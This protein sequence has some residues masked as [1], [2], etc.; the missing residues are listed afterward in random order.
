MN[1]KDMPNSEAW[2]E[3]QQ[4][5][6]LNN[7]PF[8]N[9]TSR[10]QSKWEDPSILDYSMRINSSFSKFNQPSQNSTK[11]PKQDGTQ[12]Q[13]PDVSNFDPRATLNNLSFLEQ[14]IHQLQELV[15][16]I[17]GRKAQ[18]QGNQD[19]L[20]LQQ[21]QLITA[22]LTSIIVQLISA[23]GSLL[24]S[25]KHNL[26]ASATTS[27]GLFLQQQV[28]QAATTSSGLFLQQQVKQAVVEEVKP[29]EQQS[30]QMD[31]VTN[32]VTEMSSNNNM[33]EDHELKDEDDG[34]EEE[35]LPPGS[36]EI[37][38]L[39]KEEIL[40]PHTHFCTICGK[41]F[42]RDANL[43]MHM[44]GHGDEYK[45]PAAL[46]KPNKE[47]SSE[48]VLL[49]RY[50][51]P[52]IGCKRNKEHKK[53]QPLKT[54]LCV[55]NHYKRTHCDKSYTCS[56]CHTKKFSVIADLKTHEKHC[57]R[58]KWLCSCGTTF[59]RKDKLFGHIG[60]FQGHTPAIPSEEQHKG[61][62]TSVQSNLSENCEMTNM[63]FGFGSSNGANN[64]NVAQLMMDGKVNV[65]DPFFSLLNYEYSLGGLQDFPLTNFDDSPSSF[66]FLNSEEKDGMMC[67]SS[68][69]VH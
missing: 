68:N 62:T 44:R 10:E 52:S 18:V 57:G 40:A 13:M 35:H 64:E 9:F 28:K 33:E 27:S 50:S 53:F 69:D 42:K 30:T 66:S 39:E 49:K 59:S 15:H 31:S 5:A 46:A 16:M 61:T 12:T 54:I 43:R 20:I 6:S 51:C 47:A 22:D 14:K 56:R 19:E 26:S 32:S 60:L 37:L 36:Y 3:V 65:D 1:V 67:G 4:N 25:M 63:G 48:K 45:T 58:D 38:Q 23:A 21:Q 2:N 34:K 24:P 41:G 29:V 55:K 7:Q 11:I 8:N 17:V